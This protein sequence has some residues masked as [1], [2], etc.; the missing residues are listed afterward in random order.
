METEVTGNY[1]DSNYINESVINGDTRR[2]WTDYN[3]TNP[4]CNVNLKF[5]LDN[6]QTIP[7]NTNLILTFEDI[8]DAFTDVNKFSI[9][10]RRGTPTN[11][12]LDISGHKL[13]QDEVGYYSQDL[14]FNNFNSSFSWF[15]TTLTQYSPDNYLLVSPYGPGIWL[16]FDG[17]PLSGPDGS[18]FD[19]DDVPQFKY[20]HY[21][22][23]PKDSILRIYFQ[24][25]GNEYF[26]NKDY[27]SNSMTG[28]EAITNDIHDW[29]GTWNDVPKSTYSTSPNPPFCEPRLCLHVSDGS[30]QISITDIS[31]NTFSSFTQPGSTNTDIS[32]N[33]AS[34]SSIW[35]GANGSNSPARKSF[36][37]YLQFKFD[38]EV[39]S[40]TNP[41]IIYMLDT[42]TNKNFYPGSIGDYSTKHIQS[43]W[44]TGEDLNP[45]TNKNIPVL[46]NEPWTV[47]PVYTDTTNYYD[48]QWKHHHI[49]LEVRHPDG[50]I[51]GSYLN[52]PMLKELSGSNNTTDMPDPS[53]G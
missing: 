49:H 44:N 11:F 10:M 8:V 17:S 14:S 24:V 47:N 25:N 20:Y 35:L 39:D 45:D 29:N 33:W 36:T 37:D 13:V 26:F 30:N 16:T 32:N 22:K 2:F 21:N 40:S 19:L 28:H 31:V 7:A 1:N 18:A 15:P 51:I 6:N 27:Q 9:N 3:N 4:Y 41:L 34:T 53:D 48:E 52:K 5:K 12:D 43:K 42:T 50:Y 46:N 23:I 38:Q